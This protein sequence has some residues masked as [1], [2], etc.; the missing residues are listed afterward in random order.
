[1]KKSST[2]ER[3]KQI[4]EER[5]LRQ[6]DILTAA[7]PFTEQYGIKLTKSD[8]SQYVSGKVEPNQPKLFILAEILRVS[9]SWL[10]GYDVS[11]E[12]QSPP[13]YPNIHPVAVKSFPLF[14][15]IAAGE[16]I[17]MPDGIDAYVDADEPIRADFALKVHGDSMEPL[18]QD[19][20][21]VFVRSQPTVETGQIAVVAIDSDATLKRFY[22]SGDTITLVAE[23]PR[24]PP[25]VFTAESGKE[26]RILGRAVYCQIEIT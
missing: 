3:L 2:A 11:R 16:P 25:M 9:E 1:M 17:L 21:I 5:G 13:A 22:R 12:R 26:I 19:G 23:N 7:K 10:M 4:M 6:V 15:G 18:I 14:D 8:L 20:S 24:Y